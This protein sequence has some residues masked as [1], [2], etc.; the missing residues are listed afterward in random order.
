MESLR[1]HWSLLRAYLGDFQVRES[2]KE[3]EEV[4]KPCSFS[5]G[6]TK[7]FNLGTSP[8][9]FPLRINWVGKLASFL[10]HRFQCMWQTEFLFDDTPA[11]KNLLVFYDKINK[12]GWGKPQLYK[13]NCKFDSSLLHVWEQQPLNDSCRLPSSTAIRH[14]V[15][16]QCFHCFEGTVGTAENPLAMIPCTSAAFCH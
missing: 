15:F 7:H 1:N 11:L 16:L 2:K 3:T 12:K 14:K 10:D 4:F 13:S 8:K 6:E 5:S 9:S